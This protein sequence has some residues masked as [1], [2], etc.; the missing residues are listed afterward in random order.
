[1]LAVCARRTR[2]SS[3]AVTDFYF[4]AKEIGA[5]ATKAMIRPGPRYYPYEQTKFNPKRRKADK[6]SYRSSQRAKVL[7]E[8]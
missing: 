1:M 5:K 7:A 8:M 6:K 3:C 2:V 4:V